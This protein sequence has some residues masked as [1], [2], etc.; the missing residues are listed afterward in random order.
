MDT[1]QNQQVDNPNDSVAVIPQ[2]Q[3]NNIDGASAIPPKKQAKP[4]P[5]IITILIIIV[6]VSVSTVIRTLP[7]NIA[8]DKDFSKAGMT[9]TLTDK[10]I[11]KDVAAYTSYY[12]SETTIV[13]ILKEEFTLFE[14][15]EVPTDISLKEYADFVAQN[16]NT[17]WTV[18]EKDGLTYVEFDKNANGKTASYFAV[19]LR[20][21]DAYWLVQFGCEKKNYDKNMNDFIKW[22]K[23][24]KI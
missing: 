16:N 13:T 19:F 6:S 15:A 14:E 11:E 20:S 22:A 8:Q 9:I 4:L 2:E 3:V 12:E 17:T 5:I 21:D 10:F 23:S 24:I 18:K 1:N 7:R